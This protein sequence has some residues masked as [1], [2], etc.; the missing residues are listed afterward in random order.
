[1][2]VN[3]QLGGSC[4]GG[5]PAKVFEAAGDQGLVH[6]SCMNYVAHNDLDSLCADIDVCRDCNSPAP[7]AGESG[8]DQC[9]AVEATRYY[10][11]EYWHVKGADQMKAD[12]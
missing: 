11:S 9:Y 2:V 7:D 4:N 8:L 12:L 6:S 5:D 1:M 10:V 3:C